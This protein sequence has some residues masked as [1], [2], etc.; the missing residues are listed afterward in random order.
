MYSGKEVQDI[1]K[2]S[3]VQLVYATSG[4]MPQLLNTS[5]VDAFFV[6]E[7]VVSTAEMGGIGKVIAR[8]ADIPPDRKWENTACNVLVMRNSFINEYPEIASL[9]S[10][11][12]IAG[13]QRIHEDP[14]EAM[15]I[16]A[17][18]VYGS[19]PIRS[20]GL[21][22]NPIDLEKNAFP[23]IKFTN[24]AVLPDLGYIQ[25][26]LPDSD[27]IPDSS[28]WE[29][30]TVFNRALDLLNGSEPLISNTPSHVRIGYLPSA[31]L[32]APLYV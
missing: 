17:G 18:W 12:T 4:I 29:N 1:P 8:D 16:T 31:D 27:Q 14:D 15:N 10:A 26:V 5:Q 28:S 20:A 7:S 6:W 23:H 22:L 11:I 9:L 13:I 25:K 24:R 32:Y 30:V 3:Q 21:Y 2:E 19:Q